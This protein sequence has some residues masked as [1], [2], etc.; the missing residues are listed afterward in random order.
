ME[1]CNVFLDA[2]NADA[3]EKIFPAEQEETVMVAHG[4][5]EGNGENCPVSHA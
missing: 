5:D 3:L 1:P 4:L 2:F